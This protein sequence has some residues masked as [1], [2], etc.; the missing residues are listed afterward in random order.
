[1]N[2]LP[3][4]DIPSDTV[5]R[6]TIAADQLYDE[7]GRS[8]FPNVDAVRRKARVN[9]NDASNVMRAWRRAQTEAAA[10]LTSS[11]PSAV[12]AA[13]QAMLN[14]VWNAATNAANTNLQTAQAGWE[15]ERAEAEACRFQLATAFDS[16]SEELAVALRNVAAMEQ[17]LNVQGAELLAVTANVEKLRH[18]VAEAQGLAATAAIRSGEIA[19]RADDLKTELI[20]AHANADQERGDARSRLDAVDTIVTRLREELRHGSDRESAMREELAHLRGQV[21]T[22]ATEHRTLLGTLSSFGKGRKDSAGSAAS[23]TPAQ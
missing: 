14:A 10:P 15:Q 11:I 23:A 22:M 5:K 13:S 19:K 21:E 4:A 6:I 7:G 2:P 20:R 9:M 16:Q 12:Q 1:M 8:G 18:E 3:I 17:K